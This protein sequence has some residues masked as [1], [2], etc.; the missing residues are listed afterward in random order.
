MKNILPGR[1]NICTTREEIPHLYVN[2]HGGVYN[3]P[4][5]ALFLILGYSKKW[6][7]EIFV[8]KKSFPSIT[9]NSP[10]NIYFISCFS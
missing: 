1:S 6:I 5:L 8:P 3:N 10:S 7:D 2:I 9:T 4:A